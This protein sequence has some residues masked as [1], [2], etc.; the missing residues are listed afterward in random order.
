MTFVLSYQNSIAYLMI[1]VAKQNG[2][3]DVHKY[4]CN[5]V[6]F[7]SFGCIKKECMEYRI[8]N[9]AYLTFFKLRLLIAI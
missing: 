9:R 5:D 2:G 3:L 1:T 4:F 7:L 6:I 8:K